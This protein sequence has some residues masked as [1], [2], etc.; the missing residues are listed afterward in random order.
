MERLEPRKIKTIVVDDENRIRRGIERLVQSCGNEFDIVGSFKN[1]LELIDSYQREKL[2]FDL[3]F[4]D[5]KMPGMDGLELIK[6][7]KKWASF[8]AVVISGFN[9]FKYL[10]TA[11]REGAIDY[12]VKPLM[13]DEFRK[14]V[15]KIKERIEQKWKEE[16]KVG[17][18][19]SQLTYVK[20]VQRLSELTRGQEID[21]SEMEWTKEFPIGTYILLQVSKD[22]ISLLNQPITADHWSSSVENLIHE[23]LQNFYS[24]SATSYW[25]WKGAESTFWILIM[26][27]SVEELQ[28]MNLAEHLYRK[29]KVENRLAHTIAISRAFHD[30]ALLPTIRERV[31]SLLQFRLIYGG[32]QIYTFD[33]MEKNILKNEKGIESRELDITIK[34][35]LQTLERFQQ[36]ETFELLSQF[37]KELEKLQSPQEMERN[38]HSLIV[39]TMNLLLKHAQVKEEIFLIQEGLQLTKQ[40]PNFLVLK[41]KLKNWMQKIFTIL[42]RVNQRELT[43]P[44]ETAKKWI[45]NNVG[46][47]ITIDKIAR[48]I[49]MNPTYFCE[50]FKSHTGETVLDHVTKTRIE[51]AKEL[52][53]STDLRI[54]DIAQEVGYLDTKYFSKLFKRYFG[55]VPSKYKEKVKM[56]DR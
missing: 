55:E 24:G 21:L 50:Y 3:L 27:E 15:V 1:G 17:E 4:T 54:Y 31:L 52:L 37:L 23:G 2:E 6:E 33:N 22:Q 20:Q 13:R 26:N 14:Q 19:D 51:K 5:I 8:E 12:M 35:L 42:V 28:E 56:T 38:I 34:K 44:V 47:N 39:Q 48:E 18:L 40:S 9:D 36:V 30:V 29:I 46:E 49:H 53:M 16:E 32:N 10:Q 25:Y 11:I 41:N 43:D 7:L 45:L